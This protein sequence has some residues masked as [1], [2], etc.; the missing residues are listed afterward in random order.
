MKDSKAISK[1]IVKLDATYEL[2]N[3]ARRI[4][5]GRMIKRA[6]SLEKKLVIAVRKWMPLSD[7]AAIKKMCKN[8][9]AWMESRRT[10]R[11]GRVLKQG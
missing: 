6:V 3:K 2:M 4:T 5:R 8:M 7:E 9:L 1:I 11:I 10:N